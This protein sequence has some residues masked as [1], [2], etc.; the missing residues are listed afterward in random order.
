MSMQ[1]GNLEVDQ[2]LGGRYRLVS[3]GVA[4]DLGTEYKAYDIHRDTLVVILVLD[5]AW[6]SDP[7]TVARL[8]S[9]QQSLSA[10]DQ[11]A[12]VPLKGVVDIDGRLGLVREHVEGRSLADLLA[13]R[14][15][16]EIRQAVEIT[17][18][19]SEA[20]APAHRAGLVH[21]GLSPHCVWLGDDGRV[22]ITDTGL[23]SA[24]AP[25]SATVGQPRGR[26]GYCPPEQIS[27]G[28]LHPSSDVYAL[29]ALL[30]AMLAGHPPYLADEAE[31]LALEHLRYDPPSLQILVPE[32]PLPL[33]QI[34]HRA[35]ARE[36]A[37]RYRNAGQLAHILRAQLGLE[38]ALLPAVEPVP[39]ISPGPQATVPPSP[40]PATPPSTGAGEASYWAEE[41]SSVDWVLVGL[42]A[43]ALIAVLGLIPLWRS[44]YERYALPAPPASVSFL[45]APEAGLLAGGAGEWLEVAGGSYRTA[46]PAVL[47]QDAPQSVPD[48]PVWESRLR[49]WGHS[50]LHCKSRL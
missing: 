50:I 38:S 30:Y 47:A 33:A 44:V 5:R 8:R 25:P 42:L 19:L 28:D 13:Q 26:L 10:V 24:L 39:V 14:D 23:L 48:S 35:L 15:S 36:P 7:E 20:L 9:N 49:S 45:A 27:G 11:P 3:P 46:S 32:C 29:G 31:V 1:A 21:G 2:V 16:L 34:V 12:L 37:A 6:G 43:V 22:T 40:L 18:G 41:P 4:Q 17:V